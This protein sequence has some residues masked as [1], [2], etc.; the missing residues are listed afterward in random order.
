M[1]R[2]PLFGRSLR[3]PRFALLLALLLGWCATAEAEPYLAVREGLKCAACHVNPSGGGMRNTYGNVY[4]QTRLPAQTVDLGTT[5]PWTGTLN[6]W[7]AVGGDWRGAAS[8]TDIPD[9]QA[10]NDAQNSFD[11]QELRAYLAATLLPNRLLLY[12][13]Q[14]FA[15]GSTNLEA[16]ARLSTQDG[17]Y[18]LKA[19]QMFLPYGLRLE[20]DSAY[21]RQVSGIN[22]N[23][24]DNGVELGYEGGAW[25]AQMMV[26]N[27]TAGG[28]EQDQ[29]KQLSLHAAYVRPVWRLGASFN[30]ND[31]DAGTRRMQNVY[32]GLRTGPLA[33]LAEADYI[34]DESFP[35]RRGL[36]AGLLEANW[37]LRQGH[38]LKLS[39]EY[40][41]P[42]DDVDEDQQTRYSLL[43]ELTPIQFLQSRLGLRVY[44]GIP[45]NDLQNRRLLFWELHAFF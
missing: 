26:S 31:A 27:G 4:A 17:R 29:G 12:A 10:E 33:W 6:R 40:F 11:T 37:G 39:G 38:N 8:Y 7:F 43:W 20:D 22:F 3:L 34:V 21:I 35:D 44:D 1:K 2:H 15:P 32:A 14:R 45:Q 28:P 25:T 42:D 18:Y 19:G 16:Y 36:W 41:D 24:P 9:E 23:T 5:E 30:L 13:D